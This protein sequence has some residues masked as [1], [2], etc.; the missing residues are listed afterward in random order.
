MHLPRNAFNVLDM[1]TLPSGN[2][3][4][5]CQSFTL[6]FQISTRG[7]VE[8]DLGVN[9]ERR[10]L[11]TRE[12]PS[13]SRI[14]AIDGSGNL[15]LI[16]LEDSAL[17]IVQTHFRCGHSFRAGGAVAELLGHQLPQTVL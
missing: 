11:E 8:T 4:H 6:K 10:E 7:R 16:S 14:K 5:K 17:Q 3:R 12:L 15:A 13:R 1:S 2:M 9:V